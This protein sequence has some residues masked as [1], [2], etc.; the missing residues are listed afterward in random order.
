M[1][2]ALQTK[3][4][5]LRDVSLDD[6]AAVSAYGSSEQY[7]R[8][9]PTAL[10]TLERTRKRLQL[11]QRAAAVDQGRR[12][13]LLMAVSKTSGQVVGELSIA[14]S[15]QWVAEIGWGIAHQY[16]SKGFGTEIAE[17][18]VAFGFNELGLHRIEA[19]VA[20]E[21]TSS[22][23]ILEKLGFRCEGVSRDCRWARDRWWSLALYGIL[24]PEFT[25]T[26]ARQEP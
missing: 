5:I 13:Y 20:P 8:F 17:C 24:K 21:N 15:S 26:A 19:K 14:R 9:I 7:N 2:Q 16:W 10:P 12:L 4:L 25:D 22:V 23:R 11:F 6:L 3:R 1:S 18:G